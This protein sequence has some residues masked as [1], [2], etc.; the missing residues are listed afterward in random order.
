VALALVPSD[1][2]VPRMSEVPLDGPVLAFTCVVAA[3]AGT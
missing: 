2:S 1:D 3:L